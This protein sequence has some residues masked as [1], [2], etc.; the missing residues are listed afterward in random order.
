MPET[1][2]APDPRRLPITTPTSRGFGS[3][4]DQVLAARTYYVAAS[5]GSDTFNGLSQS[6]AFATLS[7]AIDVIHQLDIA[8]N[9][10]VT[11]QLLDGTHTISAQINVRNF[12]GI[13]Q[14]VIQG[15]LADSSK[16]VLNCP[17]G[18]NSIALNFIGTGGS[19][20][21]LSSVT[22]NGVNANIAVNLSNFARV[23]CTSL[24]F[25]GSLFNCFSLANGSFLQLIGANWE[26]FGSVT[27]AV[28]LCQ[29]QSQVLWTTTATATI[30]GTPAFAVFVS[31]IDHGYV[32]ISSAVTFSGS[33]TGNRYGA[34]GLSL[35]QTNGAGANFFPGNNAGSVSDQSQY[36]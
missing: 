11:I 7:K 4:R 9:V 31:A 18:A 10:N 33:A 22:F 28:F 2:Y 19:R 21:V 13:G 15:N 23:T 5:G 1:A 16:V 26:F 6:A 14:V 25:G 12:V 32:R 29:R 27:N 34:S 17:S 36:L 24:R 35:I 8:S 30:T 20:W 3:I